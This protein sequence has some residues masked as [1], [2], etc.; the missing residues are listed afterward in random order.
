MACLVKLTKWSK[1]QIQGNWRFKWTQ[2]L[3]FVSLAA[4]VKYL[5][6]GQVIP[7]STV[8]CSGTQKKGSENI[9]HTRDNYKVFFFWRWGSWQNTKIRGDNLFCV[10]LNQVKKITLCEEQFYIRIILSKQHNQIQS[11]RNSFKWDDGVRSVGVDSF[12]D[13]P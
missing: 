1:C 8:E 13:T 6:I 3:A 4:A 9:F 2:C 10:I 5:M 11:A 7:V 12:C